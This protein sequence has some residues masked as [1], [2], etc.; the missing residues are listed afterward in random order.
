M[1]DESKKIVPDF[2]FVAFVGKRPEELPKPKVVKS[3]TKNRN[4]AAIKVNRPIRAGVRLYQ[5]GE[6][7][8]WGKAYN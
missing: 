5:P 4:Y 7:I 2:G 6:S 8:D 1:I 3:G